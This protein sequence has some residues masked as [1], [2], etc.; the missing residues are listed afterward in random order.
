[1]RKDK[2]TSAIEAMPDLLKKVTD[3]IKTNFNENSKEILDN[4][5]GSV[6]LV[7]K[8]FGKPLIDKYFEKLTANK[9][10]DFGANTY[11][12]AAYKQASNSIEI[13]E[14]EIL[15]KRSSEE[16]LEAFS[17]LTIERFQNVSA[18]NIL[19]IFQ[20]IYHPLVQYVKNSYIKILEELEIDDHLIKTFIKNFNNNIESQIVLDFGE[21]YEHHIEQIESYITD[22]AEAYILYETY[23]LAHIGFEASES[24][25]YEETFGDWKEIS[26]LNINETESDLDIYRDNHRLRLIKEKETALKPI[27]S[28]IDEYFGS[29][30]NNLKKILF[31]I[32]DF[33]KGKSVF[34]RH[35]ASELAKKYTLYKEGYF[36]VYFNLREFS[37]YSQENKLGVI[38]EYL[39]TKYGVNI[40][41]D[42]FRRK[43]YIFLIDSLDESGE[44]S[45]EKL[46]KVVNSIGMIQR[47][48][49]IKIKSNR[50]VVSSRPINDGLEFLIRN[51]TPFLKTENNRTVEYYISL[52]GFKI[53]QFNHWLY[54]SL[55][56][57]NKRPSDSDQV[58]FV[59]KIFKDIDNKKETDIY[60][61][62]LDKT[63]SES[64][65]RRP[66]F[67]YMIYQ[68]I[69]N[70]IDFL[71]LGKIGVYLS[72]IN[73]LTKDAKHIKDKNFTVKMS[74][75]FQFRNILHATAALWMNESRLGKQGELKK[76][77]LC[78]VI[79]GKDTKESDDILLTRNKN[80]VELE[81]L[82]HSYFGENSN[83]LHFQH[84]SFAEILLAEYYLKIF[85]KFALDEDS[86]S[87]EETRAKLHLGKPTSQATLFFI[88]LLNLLKET[89]GKN[90]N[91]S[92]IEKRKL[93]FPL[94][95]AMSD[96]KNNKLFC[97]K[98]FYNWYDC[99]CKFEVN[100]IDYPKEALEN[101]CI[102]EKELEKIVNFAATIF[103][104]KNEFILSKFNSAS[105]LYNNEI[106]I[107]YDEDVSPIANDIDRWLSLIV[108]NHLYNDNLKL[109]NRDYKLNFNTLFKLLNKCNHWER[110]SW[111]YPLFKGIDMKENNQLL[112][113]THCINYIDFSHSYLKKIKIEACFIGNTN[114][115]YCSFDDVK[116]SQCHIWMPR[117]HGVKLLNCDIDTVFINNIGITLF[118]KHNIRD[119]N[120]IYIPN[121]S[122]ETFSFLCDFT[123]LLRYFYSYATKKEETGINEVLKRI[124]P[125]IFRKYIRKAFQMLN[126]DDV[127]DYYNQVEKEIA[128]KSHKS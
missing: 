64:E 67:A 79:E 1:M 108:G 77:D 75:E 35:Y 123:L 59:A 19:L 50:I 68:L 100:Q 87:I 41:S 9:L 103:N 102:T 128:D 116:L 76:S 111:M 99:Y 125:T 49:P 18:N 38:N 66:I 52:Y 70:N 24:L 23:M 120:E 119:T 57:A 58:D 4:A 73:L 13:I 86:N 32:A 27:E 30:D 17:I 51:N 115:E 37:R 5:S 63:L 22:K 81:F 40:E 112:M 121:P 34:M 33:G 25:E 71:K 60:S 45:K 74:E 94:F 82:S 3:W 97:N 84:Q 29:D 61:I 88:E 89:V 62:L 26:K 44:L 117:F 14:S 53:N 122:Y 47:I 78:R 43:K 106:V 28:L 90:I 124:K 91:N 12:K 110:E 107:L 65:L 6:G 20:P 72:F 7:I 85:I 15:T 95:A 54:T 48:D 118:Q 11:L 16:I 101:W 21:S 42:R 114:F 92:I 126:D 46:E 10:T 109:F 8:F 96:K 113:L 2:I 56:S 55:K 93:L 104:A 83:N 36:P 69:I 39:L 105:S 127:K 31:I 80:I 98:L